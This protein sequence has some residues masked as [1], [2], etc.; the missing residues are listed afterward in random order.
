M[1]EINDN[2]N[3]RAPQ[4]G[5]IKQVLRPWLS[6]VKRMLLRLKRGVALVF[7]KLTVL[8]E[9][10]VPPLGRKMRNW[11]WIW[12]PIF[13][14]KHLNKFYEGKEDPFNFQSPYETEK[15]AHTM[16]LLD[17][18]TYKNALEIGAAEGIFTEMLAPHCTSLLGIE[19]ADVAVKRAKSRLK[20]LKNV[21]FIQATLPHDM[22]DGIFDLI[23]ASDVMYYFP[24]D[25]LKDVMSRLED[26]LEPGGI[27]FSLHYHGDIG[28]PNVGASVHA[29][30]KNRAACEL[31][32]EEMVENVGPG[33]KG[34]SV[35][36][37]KKL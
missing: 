31:V 16:R 15:Y 34:Y 1:T 30:M 36:I 19:L 11:S 21:S 35:I 26:A 7:R 4:K 22:P 24:T 37:L 27:L 20:G 5:G 25:V 13:S 18:K 29:F 8:F 33:D 32:H 2:G 10:L 14:E 9:K 23:V 17:G 28:A 12:Q 6:P 3:G